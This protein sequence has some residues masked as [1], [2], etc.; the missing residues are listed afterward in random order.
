MPTTDKNG[1]TIKGLACPQYYFIALLGVKG[2]K[3]QAIG[4]KVE[5]RDD[6]GY[7]YDKNQAP[8]SVVKKCAFSIDELEEFTGID[9][10]C[11]LPDDIEAKV[12]AE[13][14]PAYWGRP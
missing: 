7:T 2:D 6:Y 4:F 12:E 8:V 5:H 10:F 3:Y 1:F 14:D 9:F 13:W 11:N